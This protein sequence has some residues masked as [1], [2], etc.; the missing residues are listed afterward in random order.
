M[1]GSSEL[2]LV[3]S[4]LSEV[5]VEVFVCAESVELGPV[6]ETVVVVT[7]WSVLDKSS[8]TAPAEE[9]VSV[10]SELDADV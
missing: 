5:D 1:A 3:V 8:D 10:L 4:V 9:V 6:P 2:A 7:L